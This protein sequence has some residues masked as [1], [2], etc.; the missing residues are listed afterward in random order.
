MLPSTVPFAQAAS[1]LRRD[2]RGLLRL[3]QGGQVRRRGTVKASATATIKGV[4]FT[5]RAHTGARARARAHASARRTSLGGVPSSRYRRLE[6]ISRA[7][8]TSRLASVLACSSARAQGQRSPFPPRPKV[9]STCHPI[10]YSRK[11]CRL[12]SLTRILSP[13]LPAYHL[14][15]AAHAPATPLPH[16][17]RQ[18]NHVVQGQG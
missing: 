7:E 13:L 2:H 18:L 6:L 1:S 5:A 11:A 17:L 16:P 15:F 3:I 8:S 9:T 10:I 14:R 12:S 4:S